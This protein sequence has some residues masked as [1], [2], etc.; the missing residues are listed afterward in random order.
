MALKLNHICTT[1]MTLRFHNSLSNKTN[2]MKP[3]SSA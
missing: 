3:S 2:V 1:K